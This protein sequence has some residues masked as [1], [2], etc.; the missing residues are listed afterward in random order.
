MRYLSLF[1]I[2]FAGPATAGWLQTTETQDLALDSGGVEQLHI[3]SGHGFVV[4]VGEPGRETISVEAEIEVSAFS[5]KKAGEIKEEFLV[6]SLQKTGSSATLEGYFR[7]YVTWRGDQGSVRLTVRV[8]EQL[9]VTIDDGTGFI[10]VANLHG[11]LMIDDGAG[12]IDL[13]RIEGAVKIRDGSGYIDVDRI[14]S[15]V[16][17]EDR[18]GGISVSRVL[19]DVVIDDGKG[20]IDV[21]DVDGDLI[22]ADNAGGR[23]TFSGIQGVIRDES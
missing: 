21:R 15:D 17:I 22:L 20:H 1:L 4:V 3:T 11:D 12:A 8:P 5:R 19:G 16:A 10:E 14:A 18:S 23:F 13:K 9:D 7:D 6:L 2:F